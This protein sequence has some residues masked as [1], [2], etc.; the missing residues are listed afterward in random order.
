MRLYTTFSNHDGFESMTSKTPEAKV[1]EATQPHP[2]ILTPTPE[3]RPSI[4]LADEPATLTTT[5]AGL[6]DE[7]A[8]TTTPPEAAN[9]GE[10]AKDQGCPNWTEIH[11][12]HLGASVGH[13]PLTMGASGGTAVST[14]PAGGGLITGC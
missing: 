7:P 5:P 14:S 6:A 9:N 2:A 13:I 11:P 1:D 8:D 12:S 10:R 4:P 3:P